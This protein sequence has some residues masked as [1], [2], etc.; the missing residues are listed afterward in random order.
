SIRN[1]HVFAA[2][3]LPTLRTLP[4]T[5]LPAAPSPRQQPGLSYAPMHS[6]QFLIRRAQTFQPATTLPD[7]DAYIFPLLKL[8]ATPG[9]AQYPSWYIPQP[10]GPLNYMRQSFPPAPVTGVPSNRTPRESLTEVSK[11]PPC[12][13]P[14]YFPRKSKLQEP[15]IAETLL[16]CGTLM[17]I[18]I[19]LLAVLYY[20]SL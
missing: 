10:P 7:D 13:I 4:Y 9:P 5:P 19:V 20:L 2:P 1:Q 12:S 16:G 3:Q 14:G 18:G 11:T 15:G 17:L 6:R 8:P